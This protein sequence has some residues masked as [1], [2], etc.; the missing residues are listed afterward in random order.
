[1][2]LLTLLSTAPQHGRKMANRWTCKGQWIEEQEME[3]MIRTTRKTPRVGEK[4]DKCI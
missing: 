2:P 3:K 1:M 4:I